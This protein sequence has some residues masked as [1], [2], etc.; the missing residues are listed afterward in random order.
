[1]GGQH[2]LVEHEIDPRARRQGDQLLEKLQ[3]FE[4]EM[5]FKP[6][7]ARHSPSQ[8]VLEAAQEVH[9]V[10]LLLLTKPVEVIGDCVRL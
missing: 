2:P 3:R 8:L 10:L 1:M 7:F 9:Q 4:E 5:P 6:D